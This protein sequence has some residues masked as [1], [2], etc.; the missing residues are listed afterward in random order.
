VLRPEPANPAR[1]GPTG[2]GVS[3]VTGVPRIVGPKRR[4]RQREEAREMLRNALDQLARIARNH[5][6]HFA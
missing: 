3:R 4:V 6:R 1:I 2:T 5:V